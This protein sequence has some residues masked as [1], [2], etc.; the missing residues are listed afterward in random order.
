ME[1]MSDKEFNRIVSNDKEWRKHIFT[2]LRDLKRE[3]NDQGKVQHKIDIEMTTLKV[4][5]AFF[6]GV[7]GTIF[8]ALT[9]WIASKL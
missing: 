3:V 4:K 1:A 6:G 5:V 7:S 2:E 9:A 8:G